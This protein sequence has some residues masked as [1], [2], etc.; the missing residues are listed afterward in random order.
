MVLILEGH[1][2]EIVATDGWSGCKMRALPGR[3]GL[4]GRDGA[5]QGNGVSY[6]RMTRDAREM[7]FLTVARVM[8]ETLKQG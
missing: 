3:K 1:G 6:S 7:G 2:D 4:D 5:C 8:F